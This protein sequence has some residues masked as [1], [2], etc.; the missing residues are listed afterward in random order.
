MLVALKKGKGEEEFANL[1][2][3]VIFPIYGFILG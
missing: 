1:E 3:D 2:S